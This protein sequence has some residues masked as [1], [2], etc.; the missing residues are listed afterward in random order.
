MT[1]LAT[2]AT[3]LLGTRSVHVLVA[4]ADVV[5]ARV[6]GDHG[7]YDVRWSRLDGWRCTCPYRGRCSHQEAVAEVTMRAGQVTRVDF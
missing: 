2:K 7:I 3:R 4:T 6:R 1:A 5:T